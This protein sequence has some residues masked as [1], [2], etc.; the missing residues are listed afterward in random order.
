MSRVSYN[1]VVRVEIIDMHGRIE[2]VI[3]ASG[4]ENLQARCLYLQDIVLHK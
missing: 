4:V 1:V 2:E 3:Q